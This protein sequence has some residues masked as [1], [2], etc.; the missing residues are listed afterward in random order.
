MA[1]LVIVLALFIERVWTAL[2]ELRSFG[3][4]ERLVNRVVGKGPARTLSGAVGVI[5]VMALPLL[6]VA[7]VYAL[8]V[9][10]LGILGFA[11]ALMVMLFSLGP[12][13]L[14]QRLGTR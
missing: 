3:W 1:L 4:F 5:A 13:D 7:I 6:G 8:L 9:N 11:F 14:S 2:A 10:F 12:R